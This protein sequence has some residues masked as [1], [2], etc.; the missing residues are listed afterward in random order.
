MPSVTSSVFA[1]GNFSMTSSR[2]RPSVDRRV[3]DERLMVLDDRGD[4][5]EVDARRG[6]SSVSSASR[7]N[8][9]RSSAVVI[10]LTWWMPSR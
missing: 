9:A 10:G 4:V 8:R 5:A 6:V 1:P 7:V 2:P 3:A